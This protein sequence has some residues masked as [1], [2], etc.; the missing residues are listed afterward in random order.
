M[1]TDAPIDFALDSKQ[2]LRRRSTPR[3]TACTFFTAPGE[4]VTAR[5][6]LGPALNFAPDRPVTSPSSMDGEAPQVLTMV[7]QGYNASN[8]NRDWG[9]PF[10]TM[11]ATLPAGTRLP[12]LAITHSKSGWSTRVWSSKADAHRHASLGESNQPY[13]GPPESFRGT[14]R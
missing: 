6:R 2:G 14:G 11:R 4:A 5:L 13:T 1:R 8:G 12:R 3:A 9:N 10:A 7:P